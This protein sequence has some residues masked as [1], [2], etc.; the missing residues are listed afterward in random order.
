MKLKTWWQQLKYWQKGGL[1]G[2]IIPIILFLFGLIITPIG[3]LLVIMAIPP[4]FIFFGLQPLDFFGAIGTENI[5]NVEY[6]IAI[7][8]L[9]GVV[10]TPIFYALIGALIGLIIGK[11]KRKP[12]ANK[13]V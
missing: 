11:V 10:F 4:F 12:N 2:F 5:L 9:L 7:P 3:Y 8:I 13:K 1:I 6:D